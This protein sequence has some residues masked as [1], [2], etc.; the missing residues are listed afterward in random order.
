MPLTPAKPASFG[1]W[2]EQL[3]PADN[4]VSAT[5]K[6]CHYL[7]NDDDESITP[8]NLYQKL[9]KFS[10]KCRQRSNHIIKFK[11]KCKWKWNM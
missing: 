10:K 1:A 2:K 5:F 8:M 7:N 4:K 6:R 11:S 3:I 9:E